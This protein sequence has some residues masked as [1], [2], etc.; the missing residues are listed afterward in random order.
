MR[1]IREQDWVVKDIVPYTTT[2]GIA[3]VDFT[4][5]RRKMRKLDLDLEYNNFDNYLEL[6]KIHLHDLYKL[7]PLN[8]T[9]VREKTE[10]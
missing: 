6:D 7:F 4:K 1:E 8:T 3:Y 2:G 9:R 10:S 5:N